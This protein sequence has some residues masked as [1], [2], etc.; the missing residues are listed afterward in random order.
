MAH[1][2]VA[3]MLIA[4]FAIT[5]PIIAFQSPETLLVS[6]FAIQITNQRGQS[7]HLLLAKPKNQG[8]FTLPPG[9]IVKR[10]D[11]DSE[12]V[13]EVYITAY[14]EGNA[15]KVKVSVVKGEFYDKG[16]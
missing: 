9:E 13:S 15:W 7:F 16:Q 14:S 11:K 8:S 3:F 5:L 4:L 6:G 10:A 2:R 1:M 12:Q